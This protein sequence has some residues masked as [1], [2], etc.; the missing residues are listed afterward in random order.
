M[1]GKIISPQCG[2]KFRACGSILMTDGNAIVDVCFSAACG[3]MYYP[4][5]EFRVRDAPPAGSL[6]AQGGGVD[7]SLAAQL[8]AR[9]GPQRGQQDLPQAPP[10]APRPAVA[11]L[12]SRGLRGRVRGAP[13]SESI[14]F[15]YPRMPV[16]DG[17]VRHLPGKKKMPT[18]D[19]VFTETGSS[20]RGVRLRSNRRGDAA[21]DEVVQSG[22]HEADEE[23]SRFRDDVED[24]LPD[25]PD[26]RVEEPF[27]FIGLDEQHRS[28]TLG[29]S[30]SERPRVP[31][32][33]TS[34]GASHGEARPVG[35]ARS[36]PHRGTTRATRAARFAAMKLKRVEVEDEELAHVSETEDPSAERAGIEDDYAS[37]YSSPNSTEAQY[38]SLP[39]PPHSLRGG[40]RQGEGRDR[41]PEGREPQTISTQDISRLPVRLRPA[42]L[43][44]R[45]LS[46]PPRERIR[47]QRSLQSR[48][49]RHGSRRAGKQPEKRVRKATAAPREEE[50]P[51]ESEDS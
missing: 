40:T 9:D 16:I 29:S 7:G 2:C 48:P 22:Q 3:C 10:P 12:A 49:S 47:T 46:S 28:R 27:D 6:A 4:C 25:H 36:E 13:E 8:P 37:A 18:G 17:G 5:G 26:R 20:Q 35:M 41:R 14:D 51:P 1:P 50:Y 33:A 42:V 24:S 45:A 39:R 23:Y 15:A 34:D 21:R 19:E 30:K 44:S 43:T 31:F 11:Q 32:A 38:V